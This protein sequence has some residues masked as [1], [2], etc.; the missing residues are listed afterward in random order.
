MLQQ[1]VLMFPSA[2]RVAR[3]LSDAELSAITA[4]AYRR[5]LAAEPDAVEGGGE[6]FMALVAPEHW[7]RIGEALEGLHVFRKGAQVLAVVGEEV[8]ASGRNM[9]E[10]LATLEAWIPGAPRAVDA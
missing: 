2:P 7:G 9:A 1:N 8:L 10:T 5:G 4:W 3:G 6:R